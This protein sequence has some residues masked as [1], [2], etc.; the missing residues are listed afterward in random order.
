MLETECT[1]YGHHPL[2]IVA[3]DAKCQFGTG[4][5]QSAK[6]EARVAHHCFDGS[7]R[8]L[9]E[10]SPPAHPLR[11]ARG[12]L[13]HGLDRRFMSCARDPAMVA[14]RA[15]RPQWAIPAGAPVCIGSLA[16]S[17]DA[18]EAKHLARRACV[19]VVRRIVGKQ[20]P[21]EVLLSPPV[22]DVSRRGT[23]AVI[24]ACA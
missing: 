23:M 6:Q 5:D 22:L 13:M 3:K 2:E 20:I 21:G 14:L 16:F 4:L 17:V 12:T 8:M 18:F 9:G 15:L 1:E 11:V 19:D 24:C 7:K 10:L